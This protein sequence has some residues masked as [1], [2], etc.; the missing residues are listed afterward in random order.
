MLAEA[1]HR[2]VELH[3]IVGNEPALALY[4]SAGWVVTDRLVHNDTD[5]LVYD[6][7]VLV[8]RLR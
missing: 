2:E 4:R 1:G 3:T 6:E 7:H 8:K 5:G